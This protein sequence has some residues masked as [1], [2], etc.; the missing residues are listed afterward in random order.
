MKN[1][2]RPPLSEDSRTVTSGGADP[3]LGDVS[4]IFPLPPSEP[5]GIME[6]T[7]RQDP[8]PQ[9]R[10]DMPPKPVADK[11]L[12]VRTPMQTE[13]DFQACAGRL[14][15]LADPDRLRIVNILLERDESVSGLAEQLGMPID[16]V[17]HHLGV[18]RAARLVQTRKQGKFVIY[19][20][21]A[22][23][24]LGKSNG[25]EATTID[26]GCCQLDLVQPELP[27]KGTR[28]KRG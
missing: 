7:L 12:S 16:K 27:R 5:M 15:A 14:K 13:A 4:P 21:P 17:S 2:L 22:D 20:V 9:R 18:L 8:R 3:G 6:Q 28:N 25:K 19:S 10:I 24:S 26:L 11:Q 23:V 1:S